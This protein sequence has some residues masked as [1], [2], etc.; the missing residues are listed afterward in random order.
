MDKDNLRIEKPNI[1]PSL[2]RCGHRLF[3]STIIM[4]GHR[5]FVTTT[6]SMSYFGHV[7]QILDTCCDRF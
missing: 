1:Y 4:C 5:L 2:I 6:W 3:V 7:Q